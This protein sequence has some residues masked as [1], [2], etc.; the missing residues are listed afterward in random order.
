MTE[1]ELAIGHLKEATLEGYTLLAKLERGQKDLEKPPRH[2]WEH[3]DVFR[4]HMG[5]LMIYIDCGG[6]ALRV[7]CVGPCT[8]HDNESISGW[9]EDAEFLFNIREKL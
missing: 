2:K 5:C 1:L 7:F 8:G 4:N 6:H 9:L 3:M